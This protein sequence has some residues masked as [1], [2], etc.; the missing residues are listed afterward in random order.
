MGRGIRECHAL[1][2]CLVMVL[3]NGVAEAGLKPLRAAPG[4]R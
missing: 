1:F 3:V 2:V 4:Y